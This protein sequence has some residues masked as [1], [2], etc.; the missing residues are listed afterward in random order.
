[1]V[2]VKVCA[3]NMPFR[4]GN[5]VKR[6]KEMLAQG[7]VGQPRRVDLTFRFPQW[8]RPWQQVLCAFEQGLKVTLGVD[9]WMG[10][11]TR[12]PGS[13]EPRKADR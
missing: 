7:F 9:W 6:F 5:T 2:A 3:V 10:A 1:M 12:A 13:Q 11:Q 8:P 4:Y